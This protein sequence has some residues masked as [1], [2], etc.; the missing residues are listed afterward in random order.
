MFSPKEQ[1]K[2]FKLVRAKFKDWSAKKASGYVHGVVDATSRAQPRRV[3]IRKFDKSEYASGYIYGFIDCHGAD[4][5]Y[6][7]TH[8]RDFK[9]QL[10]TRCLDHLWWTK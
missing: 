10:G 6:D 3:Y 4:A 1:E 5:L 2:F 9:G 8:S 7:I